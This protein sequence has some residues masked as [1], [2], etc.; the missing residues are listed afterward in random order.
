MRVIINCNPVSS[1]QFALLFGFAFRPG[2]AVE[3]Y[4]VRDPLSRLK[5]TTHCMKGT[6]YIPPFT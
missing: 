1:L 2:D 6:R 5:N 4:I 3:I